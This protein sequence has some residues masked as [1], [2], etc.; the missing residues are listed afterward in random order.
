MRCLAE[1]QQAKHAGDD[2][3]RERVE[4]HVREDGRQQQQHRADRGGVDEAVR[5]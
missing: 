2:D 3:G 5:A 1:V 4:R